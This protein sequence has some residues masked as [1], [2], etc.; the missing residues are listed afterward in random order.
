MAAAAGP[1]RLMTFVIVGLVL[2]GTVGGGY[3]T[4]SY[5]KITICQLVGQSIYGSISNTPNNADNH[6]HYKTIIK[7]I[8]LLVN[9]IIYR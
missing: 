6:M 5:G 3:G 1:N 8:N 2:A 7:S 9:Q 4:Y